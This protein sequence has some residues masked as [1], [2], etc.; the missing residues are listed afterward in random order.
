[1]KNTHYGIALLGLFAFLACSTAPSSPE[2]TRKIQPLTSILVDSAAWPAFN[3]ASFDQD[4]VISFGDYQYIVYWDSDGVLVVVRRDLRDA[5]VQALRL[6]EHRLTINPQDAHRNVVIGIS[7]GDGRLHLSW[8]HHANDLRYTKTRE[9][10]LTDPPPAMTVA[11]FEPKQPLAPDAPQRVT[12]PRFMND[13]QGRLF[14]VYRSGGSGNGRTV[15]SRYDSDLAEWTVFS[16]FLFGSEGLYPPWDSSESRNAYPHDILF[17]E[18][19][20]LHIS[21]V[22]RETGASWA[23]NHDL[24]YAYSDDFGVTWMNNSGTQIADLSKDDPIE[25]GDPGIVVWEIPVYSWMMN[26]CPMALDSKNQP[27]VVLY[28]HP[29]TFRPEELEH[30]PPDSIRAQLRFFHYWRDV[31]GQ[32][33]GNGPLAMPAGLTIDRPDL[34]ISEQDDVIFTWASNEGFR[35]FLATAENQWEDWQ[36]LELTGPEY[37]SDDA[38]KHDRRRLLETGILSFTADPNGEKEGSGYA[39]LEFELEDLIAHGQ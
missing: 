27:H 5:E 1:M 23:S 25:L 10:F 22:F 38:C 9:S 12:Y 34:V 36:L 19:N 29:D 28:K 2:T 18:K 3:W 11:D 15:V 39:I 24:H 14:F 32:W 20:R 8:D 16:G 30:N 26:T 13:G 4:K 21:W 7:P 33:H 37:T 17:D 6:E 35:S 31:D